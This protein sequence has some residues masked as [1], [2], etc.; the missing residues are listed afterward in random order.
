SYRRIP[1]SNRKHN[2]HL[3]AASRRKLEGK[4]FLSRRL[5]SLEALAKPEKSVG[6][7]AADG[8]PPDNEYQYR[9]LCSASN[10]LTIRVARSPRRTCG[11][12]RVPIFSQEAFA[13]FRRGA[14]CSGLP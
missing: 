9:F 4:E 14:R 13:Q 1:E 8:S 7:P 2:R 10:P 3:R 5:Q 11:K 6:K 12:Q